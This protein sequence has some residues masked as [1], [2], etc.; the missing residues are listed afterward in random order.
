[1]GNKREVAQPPETTNGS[2]FYVQLQI[3]PIKSR[4]VAGHQNNQ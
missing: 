4:I 1:M 2:Q 3:Y